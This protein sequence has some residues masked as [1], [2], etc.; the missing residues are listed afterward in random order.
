M[1]ALGKLA[2]GMAHE[3]N[4]PLT[5]ILSYSECL[6]DVLKED[7]TSQEDIKF[8]ISE[9]IRIRN[10]VKK[11]LD[12]AR[13][14]EKREGAQLNLN[15]EIKETVNMVETQMDFIN[16]EIV[17][18]LESNLPFI[19]VDKEDLKQIFINLLVNASQA[20]EKK[21]KIEIA[22]KYDA[23]NNIVS[24]EL[25]DTGPGIL[26]EN[27]NKIFD[28]FFTTKRLGEGTGL[29]LSVSYGLMK[30]W[31]GNIA[32]DSDYGKGATFILTMPATGRHAESPIY[33]I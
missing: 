27:R 15:D 6:A 14:N 24:M 13:A 29:G 5:T 26:P 9:T 8:V 16:I 10:I 4:N 21:G 1:A 7:E 3:I 22:T 30:T 19:I 32:V 18:K 2:A 20:M 17:F 23:V 31:G 12:F 28:P 25:K 11:V 33:Q